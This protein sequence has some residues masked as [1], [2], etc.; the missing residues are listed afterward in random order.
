MKSIFFRSKIVFGLDRL[1]ELLGHPF[2]CKIGSFASRLDEK[3]GAGLYNWTPSHE[4]MVAQ[5]D[6][7]WKDLLDGVIDNLEL[8]LNYS[9]KT[10]KHMAFV[11]ANLHDA[12]KDCQDA[13]NCWNVEPDHIHEF[14][15]STRNIVD[16]PC[17]ETCNHWNGSGC[18]IGWVVYCGGKQ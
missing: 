11:Y 15:L 16:I 4:I 8:I 5:Q 10:N 17:P 1:C 6:A 3:W 9:E 14:D 2:A 18:D 7:H 12:Y 13:L